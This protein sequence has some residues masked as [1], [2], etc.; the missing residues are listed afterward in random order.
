MK[1]LNRTPMPRQIAAIVLAS[2]LAANNPAMSAGIPV[3]DGAN[4]S[5]NLITA[6]E[7]VAHTLKQIQQYRTQLQQY[8]NMLQNTMAPSRQIWDAANATMNDLR[9]SIDTLSYYKNTLGVESRLF[10][11][12]FHK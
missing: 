10:I 11:N 7:N 8:E 4:L 2:L 12:P 9:R 5:Q 1:P 3:I 6:I